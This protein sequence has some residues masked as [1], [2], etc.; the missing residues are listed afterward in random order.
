MTCSTDGTVAGSPMRIR[1]TSFFFAL[2]ANRRVRQH[3]GAVQA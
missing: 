3:P 1:N 2:A